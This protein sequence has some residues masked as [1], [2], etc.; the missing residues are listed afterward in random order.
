MP[1]AHY[2]IFA[3]KAY[4][5]S[6]E[7]LGQLAVEKA[8][9]SEAPAAELARRAREQFGGEGWLEMVAIPEEAAL[10]VIPVE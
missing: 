9:S 1:S 7:Y 3:R 6:L 5:Q 2:L 10:R 8:T 4:Q